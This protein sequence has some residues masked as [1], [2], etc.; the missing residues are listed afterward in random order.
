MSNLAVKVS[1]EQNTLGNFLS[2][3][4]VLGQSRIIDELE[5]QRHQ[6]QY[7]IALQQDQ[8]AALQK[9]NLIAE[10]LVEI[11]HRRLELDLLKEKRTE[12]ERTERAAEVNRLKHL[13]NVLAEA[14][15]ELESLTAD[16]DGH[17]AA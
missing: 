12:N 5:V 13:R 17:I 1:V 14:I 3:L 11:E 10:Q 8:L 2:F 4:Q 9:S 16:L 6:I 7:Q 15:L